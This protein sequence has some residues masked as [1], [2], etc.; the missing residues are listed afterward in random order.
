MTITK[1]NREELLGRLN[2]FASD[3]TLVQDAL[4][5]LSASGKRP[6]LEEV[7]YKILELRKER[8]LGVPAEANNLAATY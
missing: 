6:T 7:L 1:S 5:E 3:P 8:N 2:K 4:V